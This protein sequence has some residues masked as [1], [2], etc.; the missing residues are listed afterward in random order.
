LFKAK[1]DLWTIINEI[2]ALTFSHHRSPTKLS[3]SQI[4]RFYARLRAWMDRLPEPLTARRIVLPQQ[5]KLHMHYHQFV[6][7]LATPILGHTELG[8]VQLN[9]PPRDIYTDAV[10]HLETLIR[11]YY[12]RHGFDSTDSF[13][14]Q[15]LGL[16]NFLTINAIET[17]A[18]SSFL[19]SRRSTLLLLSKGIHDQGRAVFVARTVLRVQLSL[20]RPEDVALLKQFVEVAASHLVYGPMEEVVHSD[21]PVWEVGLEAK[22]EMRKQ[23]KT[24]ENTLASLSLESST[25]PTPSRSPT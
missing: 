23:G 5:L 6:I 15:F 9:P 14:V 17:S 22:A 1:A 2:S 21:W 3:V 16:L 10:T 12:L 4:L 8:G 11:L 13:L 20:M 25:S 7:D 18:G 19:E 24:L